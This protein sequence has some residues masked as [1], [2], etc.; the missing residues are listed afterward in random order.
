MSALTPR[1][2]IRDHEKGTRDIR[3]SW[4]DPPMIDRSRLLTAGRRALARS[5][6]IALIGPRQCG[7]TTAARW[8][9]SAD[10]AHYFDLEDPASLARLSEPMVALAGL[11]GVVVIDEIQRR[12]DLFPVLR[13]LGD[14]KP[15]PA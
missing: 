11:R 6:V 7:K 2:S 12:R 4:Y 15:L 10:S 8:I 9:V 13:V 14:P 5:R 1:S 3:F